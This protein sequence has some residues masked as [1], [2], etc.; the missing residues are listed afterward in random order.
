MAHYRYSPYIRKFL[1]LAGIGMSCMGI[2]F[3]LLAY[4][5][6]A[7]AI[8]NMQKASDAQ[9][10]HIDAVLLS[11][12]AG[13]M[14]ASSMVN[15]KPAAA[16]SD[17]NDALLAYAA[18]SDELASSLEGVGSVLP[19]LKFDTVT[20]NLRASSL[21]MHSASAN[22]LEMRDSLNSTA[23]D[24]AGMG[25]QIKDYRAELTNTHTQLSALLSSLQTALLLLL[26]TGIT[27]FLVQIALCG[28]LLFD[29]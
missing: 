21:S 19:L 1:A 11:A 25:L 2:L 6:L 27:A 17:V 5:I 8:G 9:F 28:S 7:P 15:E 12:E 16:I 22:L 23:S 18:S 26:I 4:F 3:T 24:L 29:F 20:E 13:A 10:T 14:N